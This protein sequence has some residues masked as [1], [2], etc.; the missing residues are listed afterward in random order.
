MNYQAQLPNYLHYIQMKGWSE[1]HTKQW[2]VFEKQYAGEA[3]EIVLPR[4][5]ALD[6]SLYLDK[7]IGI[8]SGFADEP[9]ALTAERVQYVRKDLLKVKNLLTSEE[10]SMSLDVASAQIDSIKKLVA[11]SAA[12]DQFPRPFRDGRKPRSSARLLRGL[13]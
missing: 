4:K 12:S 3:Y 1:N 11:D 9:E 13:F 8:L 6:A 7:T 5:K 2:Y 10:L